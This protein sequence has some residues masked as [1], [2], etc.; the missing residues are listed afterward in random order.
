M[1]NC[2]R[3]NSNAS[4]AEDLQGVEPNELARRA[5]EGCA[6]S[7]DELSRRFRP[8]LLRLLHS[9]L[10]GHWADAEDVAQDTLARAYQHLKR[11]DPRYQFSTWLYTIAMRLAYD[12]TRVNG[13]H[14]HVR[15]ET[16]PQPIHSDAPEAVAARR[17]E[18]GNLW[19][20]AQ[21]RL[22]KDQFTALWMR[23]GEDL[24]VAEIAQVMQKSQVGVRVLLHRARVNLVKQLARLQDSPV[25][26]ET[27]KN[28]N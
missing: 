18:V 9:R 3:L 12:H 15:L 6:V 16:A 25:P 22:S 1:N 10:G 8:R 19:A 24:S 14:R 17:E 7:F 5:L 13:R 4:L 2:D 26:E 11:F 20:K 27:G 23:F 21:Q 28:G